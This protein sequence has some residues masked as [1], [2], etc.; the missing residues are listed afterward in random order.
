MQLSQRQSAS[1]LMRGLIQ[2]PRRAAE[3]FFEVAREM[4]KL[5]VAEVQRDAF[6]GLAGGQFLIGNLQ[7]IIPAWTTDRA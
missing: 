5:L 3:L 7:A 4:G 6:N 2:K 1:L